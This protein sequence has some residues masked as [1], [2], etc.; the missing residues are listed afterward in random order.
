MARFQVG[1]LGQDEGKKRE[2]FPAGK[3]EMSI[4]SLEETTVK[5]EKSK[6]FNAPML[7]FKCVV[8]GGD[9]DGRIVYH[10]LVMPPELC[11]TAEDLDKRARLKRFGNACG[12]DMSKDG[13]DT[14][15]F[16]GQKF[17]GVINVKKDSFNPDGVNVLNDAMRIS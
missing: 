8:V 13:F 7:K 2:P 4:A 11:V 10:N 16:M 9:H 5:D 15:D 17:L 6:N 14:S 12:V 1:G 3:Y